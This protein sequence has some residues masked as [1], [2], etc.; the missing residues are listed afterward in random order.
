M[1]N[2]DNNEFDGVLVN[3]DELSLRLPAHYLEVPWNTEHGNG[4]TADIISK[5]QMKIFIKELM[6]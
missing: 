4:V 3:T 1:Y 2:K 6:K 5:E